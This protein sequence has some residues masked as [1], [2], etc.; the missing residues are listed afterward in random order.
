MQFARNVSKSTNRVFSRT[1]HTENYTLLFG[2]I[3]AMAISITVKPVPKGKRGQLTQDV[4][5]THQ[6]LPVTF[7]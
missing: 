4:E 6:A 1:A 3:L 7:A 2:F 5:A